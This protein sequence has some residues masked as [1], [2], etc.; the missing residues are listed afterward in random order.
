[1]PQEDPDQEDNKATLE[2]LF[3]TSS[4]GMSPSGYSINL[5]VLSSRLMPSI[6]D[7]AVTQSSAQSFREIFLS[8]GGLS[9]VTSVLQKDTIPHDVDLETRRGCYS[10]ALQLARFLL[11]GQTTTALM[12][13]DLSGNDSVF[14]GS[15]DSSLNLSSSYS[16]PE[17]DQHRREDVKRGSQRGHG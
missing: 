3:V 5:E 8:A 7:D 4:S 16:S 2:G 14:D 12:E 1:M 15:L 6:H 10:I 13:S 17:K 9:L 11:C